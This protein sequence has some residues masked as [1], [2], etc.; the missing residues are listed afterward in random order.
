MIDAIPPRGVLP[1]Q[2]QTWLMLGIAGLIVAIILI[3]GHPQPPASPRSTPAGS[4][5]TLASPDR[6]R[7]YQERLAAEEVRQRDAEAR[8]AAPIVADTR[9]GGGPAPA[10]SADGPRRPAPSLVRRQRRAQSAPGRPATVRHAPSESGDGRPAARAVGAGRRPSRTGPD[11]RPRAAPDREYTAAGSLSPG[12]AVAGRRRPRPATPDGPASGASPSTTTERPAS[13]SRFP[14][15]EGTV[16][17]TVLLN[18]LDGTFAGPV[19]CLVT[20]PVYTPGPSARA[21]SRRARACSARR[22]PCR[23][24][25]MPVSRSAFTGSSCRMDTATASTCSRGSTRSGRRASRDRVD[26]HYAQVFG[27]SLAIGALSGLAQYTHAQQRRRRR[28]SAT[29]SVRPPAPSLANS[30]S[31]VLDRYLNVLPTVTI[32]EGHRIKVYLTNDLELPAYAPVPG[33]AR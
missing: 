15:W 7:T 30:A 27:A 5:P 2:L 21:H 32:R 9:T 24:G 33:E 4:T 3:A 8:Q 31:R 16:I 22:R 18:R 1:R 10:V 20:T 14:L 12:R 13:G 29:S 26:R 23:R 25:A 6:I 28:T 11:A 17:E 19:A